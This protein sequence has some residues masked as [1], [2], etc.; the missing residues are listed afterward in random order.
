VV[1]VALNRSHGSEAFGELSMG[2][3][4][5]LELERVEE[6]PAWTR[7][8]PVL[9]WAH[10]EQSAFGDEVGL[11]LHQPLVQSPAH[12]LLPLGDLVLAFKVR[13]VFVLVD[14]LSALYG[15][16]V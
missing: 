7:L 6:R 16:K 10:L 14:A 11:V 5:G 3:G 9:P 13:V 4:L 15:A 12:L 8:S 2:T 1:P